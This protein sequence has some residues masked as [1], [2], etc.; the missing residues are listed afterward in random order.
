VRVAPQPGWAVLPIT[1]VVEPAEH[2]S[3]WLRERL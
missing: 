3:S 1:A 2:F